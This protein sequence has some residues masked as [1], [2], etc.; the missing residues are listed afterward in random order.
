MIQQRTLRKLLDDSVA[1]RACRFG[2]AT[3]LARETAQAD[4]E[5]SSLGALVM[6]RKFDLH[7]F[8]EGTYALVESLDDRE[9][10]H[11][12]REFTR[13]VFLVGDHRRLPARFD[14]LVRY[15]GANM[16]WAFS[17][18]DRPA[19]AL[20]RLLKPLRTCGL[21][22]LE[23]PSRASREG[24]TRTLIVA[25]GG[26]TLERYLVNLNHAIAESLISGALAPD[27]ELALQHVER[28]EDLSLNPAYARVVPDHDEPGRLLAAA[29]LSPPV[30]CTARK[31]T[32]A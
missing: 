8:M 27:E 15:R 26:L 2:D 29:Y 10:R 1:A 9:R 24:A 32:F 30:E 13:T 14:G 3:E 4:H 22:E 28:I 5:R 31:V 21:P 11:W 17:D 20:R 7:E 12:Y 18:R 16:A 6:L 25:T 19:A 23:S